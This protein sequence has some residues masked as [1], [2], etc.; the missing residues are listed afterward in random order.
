MWLRPALTVHHNKIILSTKY[1]GPHA[2]FTF[3]IFVIAAFCDCCPTETPVRIV[4]S[5]L[6]CFRE[7]KQK[8]HDIKNNIK[9]AIEVG[10]YW[11]P[12]HAVFCVRLKWIEDKWCDECNSKTVESV[13]FYKKKLCVIHCF[14]TCLWQTIV[15]AM[16][17]LTPPVQLASPENQYRIE[18]ILNLVNQKDFEFPSVSTAICIQCFLC[19]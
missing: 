13:L 4:I 19:L 9:E 7:K 2:Q 3:P 11:C 5:T 10:N 16:S 12:K 1:L 14:W 6:I 8:I 18:Y 17:N 15:T